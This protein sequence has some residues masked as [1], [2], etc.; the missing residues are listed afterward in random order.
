MTYD[1]AGQLLTATSGRYGNSVALT[2]D[3]AGRRRTE[4]LTIAGQMYMATSTYDAA[5]QV[6]QQMYPDG[7][8]VDRTY[9]ARGQL[10]QVQYDSNTIATR[11]YNAL[12]RLTQSTAGNG[13][14]TTHTYQA[15]DL[16]QGIEIRDTRADSW[17]CSRSPTTRTATRRPSSAAG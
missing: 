14:I 11:T 10:S 1:A 15:D 4:G 13:V 12:G 16:H 3:A 9:T 17:I 6:T 2:Y 5:A 8:T 7:S